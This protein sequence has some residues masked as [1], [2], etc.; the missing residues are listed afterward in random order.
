VGLARR[1]F[2][3]AS[4]FFFQTLR[5]RD[6]ASRRASLRRSIGRIRAL[7]HTEMMDLFAPRIVVLAGPTIRHVDESEHAR[8]GQTQRANAANAA[9]VKAKKMKR[10]QLLRAVA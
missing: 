5:R 4:G 3:S 9:K 6:T 8:R 2:S 1:A 7:A 10:A